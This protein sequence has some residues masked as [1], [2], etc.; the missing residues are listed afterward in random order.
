MRKEHTFNHSNDVIASQSVSEGRSNKG[1]RK[2]EA[3]TY[4]A[5]L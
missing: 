1:R 3:W 5:I 2:G 4:I